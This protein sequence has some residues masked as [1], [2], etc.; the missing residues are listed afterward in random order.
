MGAFLFAKWHGPLLAWHM[1]FSSLC[2]LGIALSQFFTFLSFL[3]R[4]RPLETKFEEA[5]CI[6]ASASVTRGP[7]WSLLTSVWI[8]WALASQRSED[9][10]LRGIQRLVWTWSCRAQGV[11]LSKNNSLHLEPFEVF[12]CAVTTQN[13]NESLFEVSEM[14]GHLRSIR[15]LLAQVHHLTVRYCCY[16]SDRR[17]C[18]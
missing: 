4:N 15:L 10:L 7:S 6:Q 5:A 3:E 2:E 17:L 8:L 9:G 1:H 11:S 14:A 18:V 12:V 16:H 13:F